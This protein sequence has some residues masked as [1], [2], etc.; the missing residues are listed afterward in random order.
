MANLLQDP[1]LT[2]PL[3]LPGGDRPRR[4]PPAGDGDARRPA[5][6]LHGS[7][8]DSAQAYYDMGYYAARCGIPAEYTE[9]LARRAIA[10][11][12]DN[13]GYRIGLVSHLLRLDRSADA[14]SVVSRLATPQIESIGCPSCLQRMIWCNT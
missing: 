5:R 14:Y 8:A 9:S 12:P 3:L 7:T 4:D 6:R 2:A 10:L 1:G 11:D 13:V